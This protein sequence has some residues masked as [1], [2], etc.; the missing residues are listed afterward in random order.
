SGCRLP[1]EGGSPVE[2]RR[3]RRGRVVDHGPDGVPHLGR[4]LLPEDGNEDEAGEGDEVKYERDLGAPPPGPLGRVRG[5]ERGREEV[6]LVG[7]S[8]PGRAVRGRGK[9]RA[10]HESHLTTPSGWTMGRPGRFPPGVSNEFN[11]VN[12]GARGDGV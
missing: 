6:V 4:R 1:G 3:G 9:G 10:A 12:R 5:H 11:L 2:G 7:R 8:R